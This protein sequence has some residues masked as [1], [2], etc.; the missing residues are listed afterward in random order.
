MKQGLP[1]LTALAQ[2]VERQAKTKRD[3]RVSTSLLTMHEGTDMMLNWPD[4]PSEVFGMTDHTH[5]QIAQR[6]KIP[7]TYYDR[8]RNEQPDMLDYNVNELLHRTNET[9]L[10]RTLDG[11]ARAFLS[12]RY[13]MRDN[14]DMMRMVLPDLEQ[15]ANEF[16]LEL[17][18][19]E[20]TWRKLYIKFV[21]PRLQGEVRRG[22]VV[23][24]GGI[25]TN[26]EIGEGYV[27][28]YPFLKR[29]VCMNGMTV[30]EYGQRK[31]HIG[32]RIEMEE[33]A[34]MELYADDTLAA[35][36]QAFWLKV[37]DAVRLTLQPEMFQKLLTKLQ[38]AAEVKIDGQPKAI[39]EELGNRYALNNDEQEG[40]LQ[41]LIEGGIGLTK[42]G[43]ANAVTTLANTTE[44]YDRATELE[45]LGGNIISLSPTEWS[46]L[47]A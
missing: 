25:I 40:V 36:D 38:E 22:D 30:E 31:A 21:T 32:K 4:K 17:A 20:I 47:A 27:T 1:T 18:S 16:E 5:K 46:T 10:I 45:R 7:A 12:N 2:E 14:I 43:I 41:N 26:S 44:S 28:A 37:R 3:F 6:L 39:I 29:L 9:R 15:A 19:C 34:A 35:D 13:A 42:W 11:N 24:A 23:Q 33:D 8:L